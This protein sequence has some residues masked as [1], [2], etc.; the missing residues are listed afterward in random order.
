MVV[1]E[2][3]GSDLRDPVE[4][5]NSPC[6]PVIGPYVL[7]YSG[8][9]L[10]GLQPIATPEPHPTP[11]HA[12]DLTHITPSF[13]CPPLSHVSVGPASSYPRLVF[14]PILIPIPRRKNLAATRPPRLRQPVNQLA[15]TLPPSHR[16]QGL[17]FRLPGTLGVQYNVTSATPAL[18]NRKGNNPRSPSLNSAPEDAHHP[19]LSI[20][21]TTTTSPPASR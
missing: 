21:A 7:L 3:T 6:P 8:H 9:I 11:S 19:N 1:T 10:E 13:W 20:P 16:I 15:R 14:H 17:A 4:R 18:S 5:P 2:C 12:P